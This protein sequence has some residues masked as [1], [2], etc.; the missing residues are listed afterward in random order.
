MQ[1]THVLSLLFR[2]SCLDVLVLSHVQAVLTTT[3]PS[4]ELGEIISDYPNLGNF[5]GTISASHNLI[6]N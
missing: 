2:P 1:T 4:N 3:L 6:I 5:C